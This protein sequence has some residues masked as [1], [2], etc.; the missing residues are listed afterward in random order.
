MSHTIRVEDE[1]YQQLDKIR[2]WKETYSQVIK[3]LLKVNDTIRNLYDVA[4]PEVHH[5]L[6][7]VIHARAKE[8]VDRRGDR[9]ALPD[10]PIQ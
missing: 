3:R 9:P 10:V 8:T 4:D 6:K 1:V 7:Q 2:D 5:L